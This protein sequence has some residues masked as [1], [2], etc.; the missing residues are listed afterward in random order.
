MKRTREKKGWVKEH[1]AINKLQFNYHA[2]FNNYHDAWPQFTKQATDCLQ[3]SPLKTGNSWPAKD[4]VTFIL[5][6]ANDKSETLNVAMP[7]E[8][9]TSRPL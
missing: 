2:E 8:L 1:W 7:T 9:V 4:E 3:L 5:T 6:R